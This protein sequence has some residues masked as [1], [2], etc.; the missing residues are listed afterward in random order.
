MASL[1][2]ILAASGIGNGLS[3]APVSYLQGQKD[4]I[5]L[6]QQLAQNTYQQGVM[7]YQ[8]D[9]MNRLRQQQGIENA[10]VDGATDEDRLNQLAEIAGNAGRGDLQRKYKSAAIQARQGLQMQSISNASKAITLGQ[11]GPAAEML[12]KTGIFG[13]IHSIAMADDVEQDPRNP[14]YSVYTAGTPD[15]NGNPTQGPH[16][17]VNQ[18]MLYQ[19]QAKPEDALHWLSYAQNMG[20]R[21]DLAGKKLD[22][23]INHWDDQDN[24][25]QAQDARWLKAQQGKGGAGH[26]TDKRWLFEW[27][28]GQVGK[29]GGFNSEQEA[30]TWANDPNRANKDYW[31]AM[32]LG[33]TVAGSFGGFTAD[34][35]VKIAN[36]FRSSP[37]DGGGP[38]IAPQPGQISPGPDFKA[39]GFK[40]DPKGSGSYQNPKTGVWFKAGPNGQ[41]L[42]WSNTKNAWVPVQ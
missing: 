35:V 42:A 6:N 38:P 5:G 33:G 32:R 19:L 4:R 16:V 31:Q 37:I 8:T 17:H 30:M 13:N 20:E 41:T 2:T 7:G 26:L 27:A 12:N 34:D 18:Q 22:A 21:N 3:Q 23:Q 11:F 36:A 1:G 10:T 25:W 9:E 15:A 39:L 24:H 40:A 29:P 28:K 14:T